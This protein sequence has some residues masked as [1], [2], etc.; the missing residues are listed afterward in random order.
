MYWEAKLLRTGAT[1]GERVRIAR[2]PLSR[3]VGLLSRNRLEPG[4]GLLIT[5]CRAVHMFGMRFAIDVLFLNA[6]GEVVSLYERLAP[7]R[8]TPIESKAIDVL[9]L[10][11]G[12]IS[13]FTV[14]VGDTISMFEG[15]S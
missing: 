2:S 1:L 15:N 4:E 12:T 14:Q 8:F 13:Q 3:L 10:P 11:A 7:M 6:H 5:R 9:E